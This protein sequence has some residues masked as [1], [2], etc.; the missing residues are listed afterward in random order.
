[1]FSFRGAA[2]LLCFKQ[3]LSAQHWNLL[4]RLNISTMFELPLKS[5]TRASIPPENIVHW[6]TACAAIATLKS[7]QNVTIDIT[8]LHHLRR[9]RP[10]A[11]KDSQAL[12]SIL[13]PLK[14]ICAREMEVELNT[15]VPDDVKDVLEPVAF[16][17]VQRQRSYNILVF[18]QDYQIFTIDVGPVN[19]G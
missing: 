9:R 6:E 4:R 14:A 15:E 7:L 11:V 8:I 10:D 12:I 16:T 5:T 19:G 2:G 1:M 3:P 17:I 18:P 13:T